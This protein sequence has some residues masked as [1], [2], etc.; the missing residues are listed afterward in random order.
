M[1]R[2]E[3]ILRI[4]EAFETYRRLPDPDR[5]YRVAQM[6]SWPSYVRDAL[7]A[8]GY[9]E[10]SVSPSRPTPAEIDRA[11]ELL[12]WMRQHL[13]KHY[14]VGALLLWFSYGQGLTLPQCLVLLKRKGHRMC[15]R[16]AWTKRDVALGAL[17]DGANKLKRAA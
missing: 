12:A 10:A 2:D 3:L 14:S 15:R 5:K 4:A 7:E 17:L 8:Y 9:T 16:T 6:T 13:S 11:E 1:T